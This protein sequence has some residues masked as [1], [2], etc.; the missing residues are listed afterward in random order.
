MPTGRDMG[1]AEARLP[2]DWINSLIAEA[3]VA[4]AVFDGDAR[5]VSAS[6]GWQRRLGLDGVA[7]IG[8]AA[9]TGIGE[10][11]AGWV[12]AVAAAALGKSTSGMDRVQSVPGG[13]DRL[14]FWKVWPVEA[15]RGLVAVSLS[16]SAETEDD[17]GIYHRYGSESIQDIASALGVGLLEHDFVTGATV[18]SDT[19]LKLLGISREGIPKTDAAWLDL[20]RVRDVEACRVARARALDPKGD[21][22]FDLEVWPVVDGVERCMRVQSRVLFA[23]TGA[24]RQPRHA[25]GLLVDRT[26]ERQMVE[27]LARSQRLEAVGRLAGMVA[28]DFNNILSV[29]LGNLELAL[30][31]V[32]DDGA[33]NLLAN[34]MEATLMGAGF[35]KRLLTL[36]GGHGGLPVRFHLDAHLGQT[37]DVY[38]RVL[39]DEILLQFQPGSEGAHIHADPAE[40]D[41]AILNLVVNARDAQPDGGRIVISTRQVGRLETLVTKEGG[42]PD[43]GFVRITVAD[44]GP[45]IPP[46]IA[47]RAGEPFFTTKPRGMGSGLGLASVIATAGRAGGTFRIETGP[48]GTKAI[49]VL[50]LCE[51]EDAPVVAQNSEVPLGDGETVLVVED[52]PLVR[53]TAL[54]RLEALG[55]VV[56]E[57][58]NAQAALTHIASGAG[59]DLVFSDII[60]AGGPS[61]IEL[62]TALRRENPRIAVLLTS[63]HASA[64]YRSDDEPKDIPEI[65]AKPYSLKDLAFAVRRCLSAAQRGSGRG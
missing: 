8:Q 27:A 55:Y 1:G 64:A 30:P 31:K 2:P 35:N 40:I 41:A 59:V 44:D 46:S 21:G 34:A 56:A 45:G 65:L 7:L 20:L 60:L 48:A 22:I 14:V 61:G 10:R 19:Y 6:M 23:G 26:E 58:S 18:L 12:A 42:G 50:P 63:G 17:Q 33:R 49:M 9:G 54:Q 62:T 37:W 24:D 3:P 13:P 51:G 25:I 4:L 11:P 47:A 28:H 5:Y 36:A 38:R 29:V 16:D 57:A 39:R 32:A 15:G 52:D 43:G 53:E